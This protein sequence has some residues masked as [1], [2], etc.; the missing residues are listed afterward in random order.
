[1]KDPREIEGS[2]ERAADRGRAEGFEAFESDKENL[3]SPTVI[4]GLL[5]GY[6]GR[7]IDMRTDVHNETS[8]V[9]ELKAK[10]EAEATT[11]ADIFMGKDAHYV[12]S[13]WNSPDGLGAYIAANAEGAGSPDDAAKALFLRF[14]ADLMMIAKDHEDE[15]IT[16]DAAQF[17]IDAL[18]EDT[19][20]MLQGVS[21]V[22]DE[23]E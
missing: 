19:T 16:D 10:I 21:P 4:D 13:N 1:M 20:N 11:L 12:P 3:G 17:R 22:E 2:P 6:A 9:A 18:I 23:E 5:R 15:E 7:L 8:T 14:A